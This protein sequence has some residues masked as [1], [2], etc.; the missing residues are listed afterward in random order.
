MLNPFS[1]ALKLVF[2]FIIGIL[3]AYFC[4]DAY[5]S[6]SSAGWKVIILY[7]TLFV[8]PLSIAI[9]FTLKLK[10][11]D[12]PWINLIVLS[13]TTFF[14]F[15]LRENFLLILVIPLNIGL[16]VSLAVKCISPKGKKIGCADKPNI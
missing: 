8:L 16:C 2:I 4:K 15:V 5:F 10:V 6:N 12:I 13:V 14:Q 7:G 11:E 9:I 1:S 3:I